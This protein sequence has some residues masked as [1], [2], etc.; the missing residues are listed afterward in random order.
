M[1]KAKNHKVCQERN[2]NLAPNHVAEHLDTVL[3]FTVTLF[4]RSKRV[5]RVLKRDPLIIK[6][7]LS[8]SRR[9]KIKEEPSNQEVHKC[10]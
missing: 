8:F 1:E 2:S 9:K 7:C 5:E 3:F 4:Q 10:A 6:V